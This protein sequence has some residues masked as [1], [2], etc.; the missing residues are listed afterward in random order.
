ML[1]KFSLKNSYAVLAAVLALAFLGLA[2]AS[3]TAKVGRLL[4]D[5]LAGFFVMVGALACRAL[6]GP[7]LPLAVGV[8]VLARAA[9]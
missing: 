4:T 9:H 6:F 3:E 5:G 8:P 7:L 1:V 2:F